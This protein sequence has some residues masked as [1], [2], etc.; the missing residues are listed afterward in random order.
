MTASWARTGN[1]ADVVHHA[2]K[3][4]SIRRWT[5]RSLQANAEMQLS[6]GSTGDATARHRITHSPLS[7]TPGH[8]Q[9]HA[10]DVPGLAGRAPCDQAWA[11]ER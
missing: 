9:F 7:R 8:V 5:S 3:G 1:P 10:A 2:D 11:I 4:S 6:F